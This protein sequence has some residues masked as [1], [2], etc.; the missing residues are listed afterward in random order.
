MLTRVCVRML[1][2]IRIA[3]FLVL[4]VAGRSCNSFALSHHSGQS[5][6]YNSRRH[7]TAADNDAYRMLDF[8]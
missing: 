2:G 3:L 6:M 1:H 7:A 5:R 4:A 8:C